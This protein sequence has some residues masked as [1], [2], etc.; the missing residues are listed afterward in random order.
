MN[1]DWIS[2]LGMN[3]YWM[4]NIEWVL[5]SDL[6]GEHDMAASVENE[7]LG[8]FKHSGRLGEW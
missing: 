5:V 8:H 3:Y 6:H 4:S 7:P 2:D 1:D